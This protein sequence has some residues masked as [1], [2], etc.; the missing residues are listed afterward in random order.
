VH[1]FEPISYGFESELATHYT[2]APHSKSKDINVM[3]ISQVSNG[4][5]KRISVRPDV[6]SAHIEGRD[7]RNMSGI[8]LISP[9][10]RKRRKMKMLQV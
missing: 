6:K 10:S 4:S 8:R 7:T 2:T 1:G 5:M 9:E 3:S